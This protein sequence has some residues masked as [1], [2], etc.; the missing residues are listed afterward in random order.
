MI[1]VCLIKLD[2]PVIE[3]CNYTDTEEIVSTDE[4]ILNILNREV[5]FLVKSHMHATIKYIT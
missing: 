5:F 4:F 3:S 2:F 1:C